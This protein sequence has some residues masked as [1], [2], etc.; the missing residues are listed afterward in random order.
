M[1]MFMYFIFISVDS[2]LTNLNG[3]IAINVVWELG[4]IVRLREG[5]EETTRTYRSDIH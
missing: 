5:E 2:W 4:E 1:V 3:K